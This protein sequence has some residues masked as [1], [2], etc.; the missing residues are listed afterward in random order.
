M[1]RKILLGSTATIGYCFLEP[2]TAYGG[3][4]GGGAASG[5]F[6]MAAAINSTSP[7]TITSRANGLIVTSIYTAGAV[8]GLAAG[9]A[10]GGATTVGTIGNVPAGVVVGAV[11]GVAAATA[12]VVA[13]N[14]L[15]GMGASVATKGPGDVPQGPSPR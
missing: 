3:G 7:G 13:L 14:A 12:T 4:G 10:A 5:G 8:V 11:V 9:I 1:R 6:N 2:L 15:M